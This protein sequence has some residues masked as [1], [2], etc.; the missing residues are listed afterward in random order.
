MRPE[1]KKFSELQNYFLSI[2]NLDEFFTLPAP[3]TQ[4]NKPG[5]ISL[6]LAD[7]LEL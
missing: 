1:W 6:K 7:K 4:A 3:Y 5:F 2:P